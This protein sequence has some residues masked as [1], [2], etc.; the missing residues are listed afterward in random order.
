MTARVMEGISTCKATPS[1]KAYITVNGNGLPAQ[2][3]VQ[4][5]KNGAESL[6]NAQAI[7]GLIN[8]VLDTRDRALPERVQDIIDTLSG[9]STNHPVSS[10]G[11]RVGSLADAFAQ[12]LADYMQRYGA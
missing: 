7:A 11:Q 9:I 12:C 6:A 10:G 5:D 3:L 4:V 2:V 1:G 8:L